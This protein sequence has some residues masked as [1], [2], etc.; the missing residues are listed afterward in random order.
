LSRGIVVVVVSERTRVFEA[1]IGLIEPKSGAEWK[2]GPQ[3]GETTP[4]FCEKQ[5]L[6]TKHFGTPEH[7]QAHDAK[8]PLGTKCCFFLLEKTFSTSTNG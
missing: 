5:F 2:G 6:L 7:T 8:T 4:G 3:L 1:G